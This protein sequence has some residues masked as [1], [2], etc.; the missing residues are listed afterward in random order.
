MTQQKNLLQNSAYCHFGYTMT[1]KFFKPN[2]RFEAKRTIA[3]KDFGLHR[4][5][6]NLKMI[7]DKEYL[8]E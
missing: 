4:E 2:N 6:F 3:R 8:Q 5:H 7:A 1:D